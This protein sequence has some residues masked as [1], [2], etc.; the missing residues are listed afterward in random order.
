VQPEVTIYTDGAS[1]GKSGA[2]G[3]WCAILV[4]G[5]HEHAITGNDPSTTNQ[6]MEMTAA[7]RGLQALKRPCRVSV[8]SDSAYLVNCIQQSWWRKWEKN[9]WKNAKGK[10][11]SNRDLWEELLQAMERHD[12]IFAHVRGHNGHTYNEKCDLLA[13][14][15]KRAGVYAAAL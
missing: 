14:E 9:G 15:A 11:V 4:Y 3:G 2:P 5:E 6:R 10:A 7:I 8:V 12:V 13:V 1:S